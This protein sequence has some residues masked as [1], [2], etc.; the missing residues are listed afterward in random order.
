MHPLAP[1]SCRTRR[2]ARQPGSPCHPRTLLH[3]VWVPVW[4]GDG[5]REGN[6]KVE[7]VDDAVEVEMSGQDREG[8]W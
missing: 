5:G 8:Q 4:R 7:L 2:S 3:A 1:R 6:E